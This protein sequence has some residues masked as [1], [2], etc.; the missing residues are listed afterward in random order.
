M[1]SRNKKG[2]APVIGPTEASMKTTTAIK[3]QELSMNH[4]TQVGFV[5]LAVIDGQPTTTSVDVARHFG[6]RHDDVLKAVRN[7]C[8]QLPNE[9][10][11]SFAEASAEVDQPNGG[12]TSYPAYRLNRDGFTLLAMGFTGK[13]ALAFKLAYIEAFNRME[14][15]LVEKRPYSVSHS[16][17]LTKAEGDT[18]RDMLTNFAKSLPQATQG[19][20]M[21]QGWSKLKSH[22]KTDYRHI[23]ASQFTE[24]VN[25]LS[26][27]MAAW[28]KADTPALPAPTGTERL[29]ITKDLA[30]GE[31][32][33]ETLKGTALVFQS[34]GHLMDAI[35]K[36]QL[37]L[38]VTQNIVSHATFG[39]NDAASEA[40][41]QIQK[42][43]V[44][45]ALGAMKEMTA[46]ELHEL[47]TKAFLQ[48]SLKNRERL[49][50]PTTTGDRLLNAALAA[51]HA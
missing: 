26:R 15:E 28:S 9:H 51:S 12:K 44:A 34:T 27:H 48:L 37:G 30:T 35:F 40:F 50:Q 3:Q 47:S 7:L 1:Q 23:P 39:L 14:R 43:V 13:K 33:L 41:K 25:I 11:R 19:E 46:E 29:L 38:E 2:E 5:S 4:S 16:E 24:A 42:P 17:T 6:K 32:T 45:N 20:V 8:A 21:R 22:F 10:L 18:L 49:E 36:R 31:T